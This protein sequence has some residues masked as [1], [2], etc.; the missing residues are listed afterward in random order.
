MQHLYYDDHTNN[1]SAVLS[2]CSILQN[3]ATRASV[4]PPSPDSR[5]VSNIAVAVSDLRSGAADCIAGIDDHS[6]T[7]FS[8]AINQLNDA[9]RLVG[10]I[11]NE[12][13]TIP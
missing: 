4:D 2:D 13:R 6:S 12:F 11:A 5:L 8:L 3:E 10:I 1:G 9:N 7:E